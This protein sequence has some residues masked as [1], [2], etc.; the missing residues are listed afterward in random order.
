MKGML[1]LWQQVTL[2]QRSDDRSKLL[3]LIKEDWQESNHFF[4]T[5]Q[6]S[7]ILQVAHTHI[8]SLAGYGAKN[9]VM[10]VGTFICQIHQVQKKR[11]VVQMV[12]CLL[13]V[14]TLMK[15]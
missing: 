5:W 14:A 7:L 10:G 9:I 1:H 2:I 15:D 4:M 13:L 11:N 6:L 12:L 3:I 8:I